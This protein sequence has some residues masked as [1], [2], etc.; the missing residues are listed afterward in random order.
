MANAFLA[1]E[2]EQCYSVSLAESSYIRNALF[3]CTTLL[4]RRTLLATYMDGFA[5]IIEVREET[6]SNSKSVSDKMSF[7]I[8]SASG[9]HSGW[10]DGA[11]DSAEVLL[12]QLF[13]YSLGH[14][15]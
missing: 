11:A 12:K 9:Q 6:S 2:G 15:L 7:A 4:P 5:V 13:S 3:V 1:D 8:F 14:G 10:R